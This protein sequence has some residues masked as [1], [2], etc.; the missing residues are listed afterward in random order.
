MVT[1]TSLNGAYWALAVPAASV[2]ATK[3]P[4]IAILINAS[5]MLSSPLSAAR[6]AF[7]HMCVSLSVPPVRLPTVPH[8]PWSCTAALRSLPADWRVRRSSGHGAG[9]LE[10]ALVTGTVQVN[11]A[12]PPDFDVTLF[13]P[14]HWV[15]YC[16]GSSRTD[17]TPPTLSLV[18]GSGPRPSANARSSTRRPCSSPGRPKFPSMQRGS[19]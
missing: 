13:A 6:L 3:S 10:S 2:D 17:C 5:F 8:R 16:N 4:A 15:H 12:Q 19:Q 7:C 14:K 11:E 9:A 1:P 18:L